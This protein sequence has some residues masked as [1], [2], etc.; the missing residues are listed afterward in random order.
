LSPN[1]SVGA[2]VAGLEIGA[3]I[4]VG[5]DIGSTPKS[6]WTS[7]TADVA[8]WNLK[9]RAEYSEEKYP[10]PDGKGVYLSLEAN[11]KDESFFGWLSGDICK[12]G[13]QPLKF[14]GK[15]IFATDKGKFMV[16]PRYRF[17]EGRNP[18]GPDICLGYEPTDDTQVYLTASMI[19][20]DVKIVHAVNGDN[21]VSAKAS[22]G[23]GFLC[24]QL[25]NTSDMGK[26]TLTLKKDYEVDMQ[27][28]QDG[29]TAGMKLEYPY[30]KSEPQVRFSKKFSVSTDI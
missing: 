21:T 4:D 3:D 22:V 12:S 19:D 29:W 7:K 6:I 14:G 10:Y 16:S 9:A 30:H 25:E 27:L 2:D 18:E 15:K 13:P 26:S 28:E 24:A 5:L 20:Q 23:N 17:D 11:D 8:G 1:L